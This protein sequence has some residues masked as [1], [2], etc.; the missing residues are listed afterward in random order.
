MYSEQHQF[1]QR[2]C[3][4]LA[5]AE[6]RESPTEIQRIFNASWT[7]QPITVHAARKW[8]KGEAIPTQA[9]MIV[10]ADI[11]G[12]DVSVLR[13]GGPQGRQPARPVCR[14]EVELIGI[15]KDLEVFQK[16]ALLNVARAFKVLA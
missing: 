9:K 7:G 1:S 14:R 8:L 12:V 11:L 15:F 16:D 3:E 4:L 2:F 5:R 13:F 10:L 6:L